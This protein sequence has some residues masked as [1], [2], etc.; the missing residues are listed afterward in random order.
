M[1][2]DISLTVDFPAVPDALLLAPVGLSTPQSAPVSVDTQGAAQRMVADPRSAQHAL[3]LT[4][5]E[6]QI[7]LAWSYVLGGADYCEAMFQPRNSRYTRAAAKLADEAREFAHRSVKDIAD[8]VAALF[9]YGHPETR[10]Y[11]A[12]DE[13]P[14]LCSMTEGSCVDI[15]A[16]FIAFCRAAGIEAGYITGYFIPEEKRTHCADMHC[17]VVTR[18][19]Q[20]VQEWDIAHHLKMGT[21]DIRPGLNPKPGVRVAMAHSMGLEFPSLGLRDLKLIGEP[22]WLFPDGS[23]ARPEMTITLRGYDRLAQ[24]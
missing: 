12:E 11:D 23:W 10:F 14:Q 4:P 1:Q 22:M 6:A 17:W 21:R 7:R 5:A 3:V 8:H 13:I 19:P 2:K 9:A 18:G 15:N 20:G 24:C 16:Y